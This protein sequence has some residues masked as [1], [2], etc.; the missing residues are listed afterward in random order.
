MTRSITEFNLEQGF[1]SEE[2]EICRVAEAFPENSPE[3]SGGTGRAALSGVYL[4]SP[5]V[6]R[7]V[8]CLQLCQ[9]LTMK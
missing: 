6:T 4:C 1:L 3:C 8:I 2:A 9:L 5:N 7:G